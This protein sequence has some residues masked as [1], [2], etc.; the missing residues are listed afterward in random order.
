MT[1]TDAVVVG[2]GPNG[3]AAALTLA[4]EGFRVTVIEAADEPGGGTRTVDDPDVPGL[5]HDHCSAVHPFGAASPF[6]R[7]LPLERY[8]LEWCHPPVAASHPLDDEPAGLVLRDLEATAA[9]LGRDG[10]VWKA[11]YGHATRRF[12]AVA[13]DLLGPLVR[14][15][16][17]PLAT[18]RAGTLSLLPAATVASWFPTPRG[19]ALFGGLAAH[20]IQPL[21]RPLTASIGLMLGAAGHVAGW[22]VAR[23]GSAAI[24]Q[25][26]VGLLED[27]GG[28]VVTGQRVEDLSELPRC[29]VALLDL[30]PTGLAHLTGERLPERARRRA[31]RWRYGPAAFKVD[32]A[33]RG[34]VPWT[35]EASRRAGTL[36]LIGRFEELAA[37][38]RAVHAER[39]PE[40]P[41]VLV[42]Q[43]AV[44]DPSREVDGV[45]PIWAYA[46]VPHGYAGD[47]TA[48]L[49]AQIERFAP[50][51]GERVVARHVTGPA[52]FEAFNANLVGGDIAGGA[53]DPGQL[54]ARPRPAVDPYR[55]AIPGLLLCSSSTP[56]GAGVHGLC[57]HH[58]ARSALKI[59]RR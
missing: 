48:R 18:A 2:A 6:L 28:E 27:L 36:H 11:V 41:Y 7:S 9:V 55:T 23:G 8:G 34:G 14:I 25:A 20:A 29:R 3:L 24:W 5:R 51:F 54:L 49:E 44:A 45:V 33:V 19:A 50:G 46:H 21:H 1:R 26:M 16:R 13:G 30:T 47:V 31:R 39:M 17:H 22:P 40:R 35:D 43:P 37:A 52:E 53:T 32:Y 57:G 15:P 12:D 58:A 56:P 4:R 42:S 59:L 10:P 38:E